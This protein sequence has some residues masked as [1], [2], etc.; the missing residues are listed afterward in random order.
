MVDTSRRH[1]H[2]ELSF[3][4]T[5]YVILQFPEIFFLQDTIAKTVKVGAYSAEQ[6]YQ[7]AKQRASENMRRYRVGI[8][9]EIDAPRYKIASNHNQAMT[10]NHSGGAPPSPA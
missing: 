6:C 7:P 8:W 4:Y 2:P 5:V 1:C 3:T 9:Q 10:E